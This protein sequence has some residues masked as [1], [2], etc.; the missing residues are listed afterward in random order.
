[1]NTKVKGLKELALAMQSLPEKLEKNVMRGAL[2]A[3]AKVLEAEARKNVPV[4]QGALKA[5]IKIRTSGMRGEVIASVRA[6]DF[7]ARWIEYGTAAHWIKVDDKAAPKRMTRRG[8]KA[9]GVS[10][11]NE[12]ATRGSLKIGESFAGASVLHPG[13]R[14]QPYL[15][16]A[17]DTKSAEAVVAAAEYIKKRLATKHGID[18]SGI[19][20]EAEA[21]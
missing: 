20:V 9:V 1:M 6:T 10:T 7:K 15:R 5:S 4:D 13:A 19:A 18:T 12:M 8:I 21:E 14:A 17:L 16:P 2:R 3:G 11:L